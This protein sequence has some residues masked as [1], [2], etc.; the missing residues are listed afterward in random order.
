MDGTDDVQDD[1][2]DVVICTDEFGPLNFQPHP[3]R[4]WAAGAVA[5]CGLA[6]GGGR[7]TPAARG[8]ALA[9]CL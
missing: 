3:G 9:G 7:P 1:D 6:A 8:A 5:A 2:P 4:Q